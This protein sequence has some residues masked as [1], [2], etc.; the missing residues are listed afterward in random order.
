MEKLN[1]WKRKKKVKGSRNQV[2]AGGLCRRKNRAKSDKKFFRLSAAKLSRKQTREILI[3]L[4]NYGELGRVN[5]M[6][7]ANSFGSLKI[8]LLG[9]YYGGRIKVP[10]V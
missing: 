9:I 6:N 1:N 4:A 5:F 8:K 2:Q 3:E 7:S 10:D